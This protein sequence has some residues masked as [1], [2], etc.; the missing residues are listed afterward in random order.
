MSLKRTSAVAAPDG[1]KVKHADKTSKNHIQDVGDGEEY[2][3]VKRVKRTSSE[4]KQEKQQSSDALKINIAVAEP[5]EARQETQQKK[6]KN[7]RTNTTNTTVTSTKQTA[8]IDGRT[9]TAATT[10]V[11]PTKALTSRPLKD[12]SKTKTVAKQAREEITCVVGTSYLSQWRM[13]MSDLAREC[14]QIHFNMDCEHGL[15]VSQFDK[16]GSLFIDLKLARSWWNMLFVISKRQSSVLPATRT[17]GTATS[18]LAAIPPFIWSV[19][20][21]TLEIIAKAMQRPGFNTY[22]QLC[23][24]FTPVYAAFV[25]KDQ[26]VSSAHLPSVIFLGTGVHNGRFQRTVPGVIASP[27][28]TFHHRNGFRLWNEARDRPFLCWRAPQKMLKSIVQNCQD[29]HSRCLRFRV[30]NDSGH[31]YVSSAEGENGHSFEHMFPPS[32][33][34]WWSRTGSTTPLP[35]LATE[36]KDAKAAAIQTQEPDDRGIDSIHLID[37]DITGE[38]SRLVQKTCS[39]DIILRFL[40]APMPS[41]SSDG[42]ATTTAEVGNVVL[43]L[44]YELDNVDVILSRTKSDRD[45][46]PARPTSRAMPDN[47]ST[48]S[49]YHEDL[50]GEEGD[51]IRALSSSPTCDSRIIYRSFSTAVRIRL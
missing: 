20:R 34:L 38:I 3:T 36:R 51:P 49:S 33:H 31:L 13:V 9:Q 16:S 10:R 30:A 19:D 7:H 26:H 48:K 44:V 11:A 1:S 43:E 23:M 50:V 28:S 29:V 40:E 35:S 24:E 2:V 27:L 6:M 21:T 5:D 39:T 37:V 42:A 46:H 22:E 32:E 41:S 25:N 18:S 45:R 17:V 8:S 12:E 47:K 14:D 15:R 4:E